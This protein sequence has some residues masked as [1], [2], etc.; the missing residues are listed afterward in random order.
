MQRAVTRGLQ[1]RDSKCPEHIG[2]DETSFRKG[3]NYVTIV[4]DQAGGKVLHVADE[5]KT[6]SLESYYETLTEEQ[7]QSIKSGDGY[8]AC[9]HQ[10]NTGAHT[11]CAEQDRF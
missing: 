5:R 1:R 8:V 3:H 11:R 9:L 2:V 10:S 6:A 4:S 7:K